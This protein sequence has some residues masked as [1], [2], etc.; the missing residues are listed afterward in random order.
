M[1]LPGGCDFGVRPI[2]QHLKCFTALG[3]THE[4]ESGVVVLSAEKLE[5]AHVYFDVVTVG[6]TINAMLC[7]VLA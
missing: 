6:A 7:S 3:A 5:G 4:V 1:P 2:D